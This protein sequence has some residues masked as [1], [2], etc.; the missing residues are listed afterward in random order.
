MRELG[1][2]REK[3]VG[4]AREWAFKR[5]P[6]YLDFEKLGGDCTNFASQC[7]YAGSGV[8]NHTK[9][10]GWYYYSADD[11]A[12]A[13]TGVEYFYNFLTSNKGEGP[14]GSEA[15]ESEA[16]PGDIVQL[17]NS[18]GSFYHSPVITSVRNGRIYVAAHSFDAYDRPLSSYIYD[19]ARLIHIQ[20]TRAY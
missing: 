14:Y 17:G 2:D 3:A 13:W 6:K 16:E 20:G 19:R 1:Y 8:M 11:R 18:E 10:F 4:Y 9:T 12:P 15:D 5:N 7:V